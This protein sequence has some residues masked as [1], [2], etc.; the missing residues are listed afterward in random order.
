LVV[1][2]STQWFNVR[3]NIE[4]MPSGKQHQTPLS[5]RMSASNLPGAANDFELP[6]EVL[7]GF[8]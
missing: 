2:K 1:Q 4:R 6:K 3:L 8:A 7:Q 5:I